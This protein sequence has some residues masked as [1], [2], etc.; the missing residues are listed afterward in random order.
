MAE[1]RRQ[2]SAEDVYANVLAGAADALD[3]GITTVLDWCHVVNTPEHPEENLRALREVGLR[4][5]FL[6]GA[7][8]SRKLQEFEGRGRA[9]GL[10]GARPAD[11][12]ARF[13]S[14]DGLITFGLACRAPT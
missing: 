2:Y 6:Y 13:P 7:S 14:N 5:V 8:M 9:R 4:S 12:R 10:L 11:P 3:N 1:D